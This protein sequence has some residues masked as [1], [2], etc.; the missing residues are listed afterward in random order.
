MFFSFLPHKEYKKQPL[1]Q[2]DIRTTANFTA[3]RSGHVSSSDQQ[4]TRKTVPGG[5]V[6]KKPPANAANLGLSP[7]L[8]RFP[9]DGNGN[10]LQYS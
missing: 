2:E 8:G 1:T 3:A 6:V 4:D 5:P 10:P 7:R 9:G